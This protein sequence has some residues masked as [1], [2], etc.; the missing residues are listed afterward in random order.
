MAALNKQI[1]TAAMMGIS[2]T[3]ALA[4]CSS[5]DATDTTNSPSTSSSSAATANGADPT[6]GGDYADGEY[7]A[8]GEYGTQDSSIGVSLTLDNGVVTEVGVEPHATNETS[9]DYQERFAEAV[10]DLVVGQD[11]DDV[12]LDRVAGSSGT[13]DGFNDAIQKIKDEAST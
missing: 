4:G 6:P 2:A 12:N 1:A 3:A 5:S 10:P 11:I 9:R 7:S 8:D 13:P